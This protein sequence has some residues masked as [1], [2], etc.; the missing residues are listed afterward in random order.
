MGKVRVILAGMYLSA[1]SLCSLTFKPN[2]HTILDENK[3]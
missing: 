3:I 2:E 1:S